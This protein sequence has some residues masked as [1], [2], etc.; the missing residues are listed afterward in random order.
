MRVTKTGDLRVIELEEGRHGSQETRGLHDGGERGSD[1][2]DALDKVCDD[3]LRRRSDPRGRGVVEQTESTR[4][5]DQIAG[6][7]VTAVG[8]G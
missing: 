8:P 5:D 2:S 4:H 3:R 1:L 7:H 6:L